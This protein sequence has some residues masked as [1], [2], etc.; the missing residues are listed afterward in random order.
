MQLPSIPANPFQLTPNWDERPASSWPFRMT[1]NS[2]ILRES[3]AFP[4][5]PPR[6]DRDG[7]FPFLIP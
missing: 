5:Q 4:P 2:Q 1:R 7:A 6:M 3:G